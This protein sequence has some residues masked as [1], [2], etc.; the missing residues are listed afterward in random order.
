[1]AKDAVRLACL[2]CGQA[3][4]VPLAMLESGPKCANALCCWLVGTLHR[5]TRKPTIKQRDLMVCR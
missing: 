2:S 5:L 3:N 4:R 1:M